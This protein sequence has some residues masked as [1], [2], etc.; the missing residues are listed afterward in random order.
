MIIGLLLDMTKDVD[1][2]LSKGMSFDGRHNNPQMVP[3]ASVLAHASDRQK[4]DNVI[5]RF[6]LPT[7]PVPG[8]GMTP[9]LTPPSTP[10]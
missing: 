2:L 8:M 7:S 1:T 5:A 3:S 9:N 6:L 10:Y 4:Q